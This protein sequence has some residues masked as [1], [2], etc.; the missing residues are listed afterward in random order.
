MRE[1][2]SLIFLKI[3]LLEGIVLIFLTGQEVST[4]EIATQHVE[5]NFNSKTRVGV[6]WL[7]G[8]FSQSVYHCH[9]PLPLPSQKV[10]TGEFSIFFCQRQWVLFQSAWNV[11]LVCQVSLP[12]FHD[13][14]CSAF[15]LLFKIK[16][17]RSVFFRSIKANSQTHLPP[18][19]SPS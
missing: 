15:I 10:Q 2:E 14:Q 1:K 16:N 18:P 19:P 17:G 5:A 3:H 6:G 13:N 7:N 4:C 8:R 12:S 9:D 11:E